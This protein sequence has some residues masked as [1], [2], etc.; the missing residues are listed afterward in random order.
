MQLL[1]LCLHRSLLH[2]CFVVSD[3][4]SSDILRYDGVVLLHGRWG[5]TDFLVRVI[6]TNDVLTHNAA[7][8]FN[9]CIGIC[10]FDTVSRAMTQEINDDVI[11]DVGSIDVGVAVDSSVVVFIP[12]HELFPIIA[13]AKVFNAIVLNGNMV[14]VLNEDSTIVRTTDGIVRYD[15]LMRLID[16]NAKEVR[17][18]DLVAGELDATGAV[19][20]G[21]Q[22]FAR[23]LRLVVNLPS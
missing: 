15:G 7:H 20:F 3:Q 9:K 16:L 4:A 13:D 11:G 22:Y 19:G 1:Y 23:L 8:I 2:L 5:R 12:L 17:V 6:S 14:R 18:E 21:S 10:D